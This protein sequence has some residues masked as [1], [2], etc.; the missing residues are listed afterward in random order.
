MLARTTIRPLGKSPKERERRHHF[1]FGMW[2]KLPIKMTFISWSPRKPMTLWATR[3][4]SSIIHV[5]WPRWWKIFLLG[6]LEVQR[7]QQSIGLRMVLQGMNRES[8]YH[9]FTWQAGFSQLLGLRN[10][11]K[12]LGNEIRSFLEDMQRRTGAH[13]FV[14]AGFETTDGKVVVKKYDIHTATTSM[15]FSL[16]MS[17][18]YE[19]KPRQLQH[20]TEEMPNWHKATWDSWKKYIDDLFRE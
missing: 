18:R 12:N 5:P 7:T 15:S 2:W 14:F 19:S 17:P 10:A 20:F 8:E 1:L 11:E 13:L 4:G 9:L 16:I 6:I 3:A